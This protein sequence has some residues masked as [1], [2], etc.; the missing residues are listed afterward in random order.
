MI[1]ST[2]NFKAQLIEI[3]RIKRDPKNEKSEMVDYGKFTLNRKYRVHSV[4]SSETCTQF[5]VA[6][7]TGVFRWILTGVFRK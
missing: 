7:D 3:P 5:L 2:T 1:L 6:D 4:Y